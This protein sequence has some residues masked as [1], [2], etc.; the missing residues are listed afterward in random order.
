MLYSEEDVGITLLG[1]VFILASL[2][3]YKGYKKTKARKLYERL[4]HG[5]P[6]VVKTILTK[7]E[8][9]E[10]SDKPIM[11]DG[12]IYKRNWC[13]GYRWHR[14]REVESL[15]NVVT[16]EEVKLY[17]TERYL[18]PVVSVVAGKYP[19]TYYKRCSKFAVIMEVY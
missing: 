13:N 11:I 14:N 2:D 19:N 18:S 8:L 9:S 15:I 12:E 6:K 4:A 7:E 16:G 1:I 17:L 3:W 5:T 10:H